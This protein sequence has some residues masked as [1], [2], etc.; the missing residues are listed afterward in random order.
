[1]QYKFRGKSKETKQ[2]VFGSLVYVSDGEKKYP[3]IVIS[4]GPHQ[5]DWIDVIPE[6]VGMIFPYTDKN[7]NEIYEGDILKNRHGEYMIKDYVDFLNYISE[8]YHSFSD[9]EVTGKTIHD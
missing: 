2:W 5:F 6:T 1:M 3:F 4:Y 9:M 7:R 8:N